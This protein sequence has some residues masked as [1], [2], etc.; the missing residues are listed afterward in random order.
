MHAVFQS[1]K[2]VTKR[3]PSASVVIAVLYIA[4]YRVRKQGD[5]DIAGLA[6][7][8]G[9]SMCGATRKRKVVQPLQ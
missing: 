5:T 8:Y 6:A 1:Y 9:G 4:K 3:L 2:D 7:A